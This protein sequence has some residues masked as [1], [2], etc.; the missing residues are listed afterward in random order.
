[1]PLFEVAILEEPTKKE[2]EEEGKQEQLKFGPKPVIARDEQS[3][4]VS[5]VLECSEEIKIEKSRMRIL[6]RPFV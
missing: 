3:A 4:C 1:M 5:A 6:I 2:Q